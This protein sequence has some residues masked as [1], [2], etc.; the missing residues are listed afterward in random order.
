MRRGHIQGA[1]V[2]A[3]PGQIG[4]QFGHTN[5]AQQIAVRRI[6]PDTSRRRHPDIAALVAFHAVGL[7]RLKLRADAI[8]EDA[9]V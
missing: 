8:G 1:E 2:G 5:L 9:G 6:D 4:D 3:A 7:A